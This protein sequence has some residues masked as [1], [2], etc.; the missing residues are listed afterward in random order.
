MRRILPKGGV[1]A[2][3]GVQKGDFTRE[4]LEIADPERLHLVDLWY[5]LGKEWH[6]GRG[7]RS[8]VA[9]LKGILDKFEDELVSGRVALNIGDDV[10]VLATFPDRYFDWVYLDTLHAYEHTKRE[11]EI[12]KVK[13][14]LHGI[15]AGDDWRLD[16]THPHHGVCRAVTEFVETEPYDLVYASEDDLQWAVKYAA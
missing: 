3:L 10:E 13:V 7:S 1:A 11:L 8:T 14:K 2:E 4:L 12:L 9:A 5:L 15:I 16:P 6:W